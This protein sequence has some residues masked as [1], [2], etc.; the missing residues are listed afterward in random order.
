MAGPSPKN[1]VESTTMDM[2]RT[3]VTKEARTDPNFAPRNA[4]PAYAP[5]PGTAARK[6]YV[7]NARAEN[8]AWGACNASCRHSGRL[9]A[10][11]AA[12]YRQVREMEDTSGKARA[13]NRL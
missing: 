3:Y 6:R 2:G 9:K 5:N 12:A 8:T 13:S 1:S 4:N 7:M 10:A 11:P